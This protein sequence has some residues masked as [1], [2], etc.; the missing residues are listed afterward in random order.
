MSE[1]VRI[2]WDETYECYDVGVLS[3]DA[4][5]GDVEREGEIVLS[6]RAARRRYG[7]SCN[8]CCICCG[9]RIPLTPG[10][11]SRMMRAGLGAG[12]SVREWLSRY[13]RIED[14][15][16]CLD[17]TLKCIDDICCLWDRERSICSL[18]EARPFVCRT[19]ICA[20]FS[21]RL[22]ELRSQIVNYGENLLEEMIVMGDFDG[23]KFAGIP[24]RNI[25]SKE[26]WGWLR[27]M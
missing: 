4:A 22:E 3:D 21:R 16:P 26:L 10:D 11:I 25:C 24:L 9:G 27:D 23:N 12:K 19:Y 18:Y 8:G 6:G 17:V 5:V 7:S 2:W 20:P 14:L 15:G 1:K 13:C